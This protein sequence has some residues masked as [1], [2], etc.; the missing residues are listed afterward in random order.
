MSSKKHSIVG[1]IALIK[2]VRCSFLIVIYRTPEEDAEEI[3][4]KEELKNVDAALKRLKKM[5]A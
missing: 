2:K 5:V 3:R 1:T 4:L